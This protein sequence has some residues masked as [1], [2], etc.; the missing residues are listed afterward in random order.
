MAIPWFN[1]QRLERATRSRLVR[2][3]H[4]PVDS[5]RLRQWFDQVLATAGPDSASWLR[6]WARPALAAAAVLA[7]AILL[8]LGLQF[9]GDSTGTVSAASLAGVHRNILAGQLEVW[10][11]ANEKEA[12]R[13]LSQH[14]VD[15]PGLPRFDQGQMTGCSVANHGGRNV[16]VLLLEYQG[17]PVTVTVVGQHHLAPQE[18]KPVRWQNTTFHVHGDGEVATAMRQVNERWL[19]VTGKLPT[20]TLIEL[21]AAMRLD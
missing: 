15:S 6:Q 9:Q 11:A 10:P 14:G 20:Q 3:G 17:R 2:L 8:P 1:E 12:R 18:Q 5:T 4:R 21:N 16:P 19:C 7:L 13:Q